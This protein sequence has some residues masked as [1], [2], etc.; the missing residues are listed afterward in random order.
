MVSEAREVESIVILACDF[1]I[2]FVEM[3]ITSLV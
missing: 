1:I 3:F 2:S